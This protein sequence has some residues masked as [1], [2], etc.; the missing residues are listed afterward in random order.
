[1]SEDMQNPAP[2]RQA[3]KN[4]L[5]PELSEVLNMLKAL[6]RGTQD[7]ASSSKTP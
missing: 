2:G 6:E 7:Q 3:R 5:S 4:H 1:M